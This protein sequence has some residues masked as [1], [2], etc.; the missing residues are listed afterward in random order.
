MACCFLGAVCPAVLVGGAT[1]GVS[2]DSGEPVPG[3]VNKCATWRALVEEEVAG[4]LP[5][6]S[7]LLL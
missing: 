2:V 4:A 6:G 7:A 3:H 1:V 5:V